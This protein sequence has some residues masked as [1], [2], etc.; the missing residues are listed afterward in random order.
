M[1]QIVKR[2][3]LFMYLVQQVTWTV[4]FLDENLVVDMFLGME[5]IDKNVKIV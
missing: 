3:I 1:L 5:F 4:F 2:I